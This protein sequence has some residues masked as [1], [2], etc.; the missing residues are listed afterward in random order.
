MNKYRNIERRNIIRKYRKN[1]CLTIYLINMM[2]ILEIR[3]W[4][5]I[6]NLWIL[7][8]QFHQLKFHSLSHKLKEI[9]SLQFHNCYNHLKLNLLN[10]QNLLINYLN[11]NNNKFLLNH[12]LYN[13]LLNIN[14]NIHQLHNYNNNKLIFLLNSYLNLQWKQLMLILLNKI[15]LTF[16]VTKYLQIYHL[17][18]FHLHKIIVIIW[19]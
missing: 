1:K 11:N 4:I 14:G 19:A 2:K 8:H 9:N 5:K 16:K 12:K 3:Q 18:L 17:L 10:H 6:N 13:L 7:H 15:L